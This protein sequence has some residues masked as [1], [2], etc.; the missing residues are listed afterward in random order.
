MS[1]STLHILNRGPNQPQLLQHLLD[2]LSEGDEILLIE[3]GVYWASEHLAK[4]FQ[5][6]RP[7]VLGA[8]AE[9][10]GLKALCG[11]KITDADFVD[12]C[13]QHQRSVS[14]C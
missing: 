11:E 3:D 1:E 7:K 12:L 8:D 13:V 5:S 10:R 4:R 2:A 9:A 6:F 14:W